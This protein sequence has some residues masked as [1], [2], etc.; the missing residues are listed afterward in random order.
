MTPVALSLFLATSGVFMPWPSFPSPWPSDQPIF[1]IIATPGSPVSPAALNPCG[2][3]GGGAAARGGGGG[4]G[5]AARGGG[6]GGGGG[7]VRGRFSASAMR[8]CS[9][10]SSFACFALSSASRNHSS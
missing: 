5:G 9:S 4:G 8:R 3:G 1:C 7:A 6:G 2:S 10:W